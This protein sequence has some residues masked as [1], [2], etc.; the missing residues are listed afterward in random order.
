VERQAKNHE[1]DVNSGAKNVINCSNVEKTLRWGKNC[2]T[3][4]N[5][6]TLKN[7]EELQHD[8]P[9]PNPPGALRRDTGLAG[10]VP[11]ASDDR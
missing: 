3:I 4:N 10:T 5:H 2:A 6:E 8:K 7:Q 9:D 11:G 1:E